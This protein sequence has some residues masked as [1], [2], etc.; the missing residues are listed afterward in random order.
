MDF[1]LGNSIWVYAF[2]FFGKIF[3]VSIP[4]RSGYQNFSIGTKIL[5]REPIVFGLTVNGIN[6]LNKWMWILPIL[7]YRYSGYYSNNCFSRYVYELKVPAFKIVLFSFS[8]WNVSGLQI[9]LIDNCHLRK[10][11]KKSTGMLSV[12]IPIF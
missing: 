8:S 6:K 9:L 4:D 7:A 2:I 12:I 11:N 3:E 5:K 10:S 1:F